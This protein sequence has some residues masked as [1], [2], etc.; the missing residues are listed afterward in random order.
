MNQINVCSILIP[1]HRYHLELRRLTPLF[2]C[3]IVFTSFV[4]TST[5]IHALI[6][7]EQPCNA[8]YLTALLIGPVIFVTTL[9]MLPK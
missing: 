8:T 4:G 6:L 7:S 3:C 1:S 5:L 9:E 2:D